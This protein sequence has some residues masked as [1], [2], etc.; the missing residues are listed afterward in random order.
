[1]KNNYSQQPSQTLAKAIAI[2]DAFNS[3]Q[4]E[5]GIRELGRE[6]GINSATVHRLVTT[7]SSAGYLE[8]NSKS[9]RY[10]VGPKVMTLANLYMRQNPISAVARKVFE[11]YADRFEHNFYLGKL[12]NQGVVYLSVLDGRGPIRIVVETGRTA[13]LHATATG[14]LL[15]AFQ[16]D[17]Y[18]RRFL[19]EDD[20]IAYTPRTITDPDLLRKALETIRQQGYA[21][22][23]GEFY[24]EVGAISVP[25]ID[26]R[27]RATL[28]VCLA[29]PRHLITQE[30]ITIEELLQLARQISKEISLRTSATGSMDTD[31]GGVTPAAA[32]AIPAGLASNR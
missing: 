16:N 3:K 22:N 7:L 30:I 14:K 32:D 5:R 10:S 4:P 6:L 17:E 28:G 21:L 12:S 8:Q 26:N 24:D 25:L 1:M 20:L 13:A 29:Y 27:S 15:L 2:L 9:Q 11:S 19:T 18:V 31:D 23:D